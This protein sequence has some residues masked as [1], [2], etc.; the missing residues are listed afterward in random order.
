[1]EEAQHAPRPTNGIGTAG[2]V[3]SLVGIVLCGLISPIGLVL[4]II[5]LGR[6]PKGLAIAGTVIGGIGTLLLPVVILVVWVTVPEAQIEGS[7][8]IV[9]EAASKIEALQKEGGEPPRVDE[10][11]EVLDQYIDLYGKRLRYE[12]TEEGFRV[13]S[14]GKDREF[15][16]D[17]DIVEE[18]EG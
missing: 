7:K 1:V 15:D 12:P 5:G 3:V 17:D 9:K 10:A 13:R 8:A 6:E 11:E 14:A 2:F 16:T 4:S 18:R